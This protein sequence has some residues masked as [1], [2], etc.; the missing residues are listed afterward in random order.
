MGLVQSDQEVSI[1]LL[2]TT[3]RYLT[4][5]RSADRF[6]HDV[7]MLIESV[8]SIKEE[9]DAGYINLQWNWCIGL[10]IHS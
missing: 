5:S 2:R 9:E 3:Q 1:D 7:L 10:G 6:P 8:G 4:I